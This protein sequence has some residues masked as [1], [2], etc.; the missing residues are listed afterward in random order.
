MLEL[1]RSIADRV[2][3][4]AQRYRNPKTHCRCSD[5]VRKLSVGVARL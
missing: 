2:D 3:V 1:R 4:E 5:E